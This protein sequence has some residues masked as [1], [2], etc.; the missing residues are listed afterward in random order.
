M[1]LFEPFQLGDLTLRNRVAMAPMTRARANAAGVVQ[2]MTATYYRQR[3]SAGLLITEGTNISA[4]AIGSPL[5]PGIFTA[6]QTAAWRTVTDA[7]HEAGG[8]IVMQL[9]HTGRVGHSLVRNGVLP[10]APSAVAIAGQKHFTPEGP[11]DYEVPRALETAEVWATIDDYERAAENAKSAGF[12]G[13]ELHAAFGYLPNQFLV[14]GANQRTDEFGGSV[15]NRARFVIEVMRRLVRVWGPSRV[16]IKLSPTIPYNG[17]TD[18]NPL[19][20]FGYLLGQLN[21]L[22]LSYVQLM[23]PLFPIDAFPAESWPRD[24][25]EAFGPLTRATVMANGGYDQAKA[26]AVLASGKAQLVSFGAPYVA[27]PDL[28]E[29]FRAGAA[30]AIPDRATMF[31]GG[32]HG[33]IDYPT[34]T[35]VSHQD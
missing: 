14:D 2:P 11:K 19:A 3:A 33:Y 1:S 22:P 16:G 32:E 8:A 6:E 21:E 35:S 24:T 13:V 4:D 28:V 27:N 9:W 26:E 20:T 23:Q 31:G 12:D 30:L 25:I 15:E 10:V 34:G 29:R 18:S 17:I 7:V 5:T